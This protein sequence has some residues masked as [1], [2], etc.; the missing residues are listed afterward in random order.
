VAGGANK[1]CAALPINAAGYVV[2]NAGPRAPSCRAAERYDLHVLQ[3]SILQA[4]LILLVGSGT[5]AIFAAIRRAA[6]M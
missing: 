3:I 5:L 6:D 2:G 4:Q 1:L